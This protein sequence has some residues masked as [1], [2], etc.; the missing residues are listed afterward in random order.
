MAFFTV[1]RIFFYLSFSNPSDPVPSAL[2]AESFWIGFKFDLRLALIIN[3]PV[4][5]L[6]WI[7]PLNVFESGFGKRFWPSV[8]TGANV[9]LLIIYFIDFGHFAYLRG[10]INATAT[11]FFYNFS[12][13][14]GMIWETY[15]VVWAMLAVSIFGIGIKRIFDRAILGFSSRA[16]ESRLSAPRAAVLS[17]AVIAVSASGIYGKF[18]Y[19]PLRWS[20]AFFST[21]EFSSSLSLNPVLFFFDTF[22]KRQDAYDPEKVK[23]S[24]PLM[25]RYLGID[26]PDPSNPSY[27]RKSGTTGRSG[28]RPNVVIV[29]L[30][31][32]CYYKTGLSGNPLDPTPRF[33]EIARSGALF[34][35]YYAPSAG[36][37][38][39]IFALMTGIPDV[40]SIRTSSRNPLIVSQH[41]IAN[42]FEGYEK[43]YFLGGSLNWANIR[44]LLRHNISDLRIYEEGSYT[45]PRVDVWGISDLSLFEEANRVLRG[46]K[47]PFFAVIQTSGNHR[48]YTVPDDSRGFILKKQSEDEIKKHGFISTEEYNSFRFMDHSIGFFIDTAKKEDY[49]KNTIFVFLGDHG[50]PGSADHMPRS[51]EQ[52]LLTS[53]HVPFLIYA[54]GL[55]I[56]SHVYE[57][58]ASEV[59]V[60]PTLARLAGRP[61]VN[62]TFG[63]DLFDGSFSESRFAFT[64][65]DQSSVPEIGLVG[66]DYYFL[67]HADGS[68]RRL[69]A[70]AAADPRE[71]LTASLP[72]VASGME[73]VTRSIYETARYLPYI[74]SPSKLALR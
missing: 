45:S 70:L 31:S 5:I 56:K 6:S 63:R 37:A 17:F 38:R 12:T 65:R 4:F 2:L 67:M 41:T 33:D 73:T 19:Y 54:P 24:Y 52:L 27:V 48:P 8:L 21:N 23:E 36:T 14:M 40:E 35:R 26:H 60:L 44:G 46:Q 62:S 11:Q 39:S 71:N 69:H 53:N 16:V 59:D 58:V 51:E 10:R 42:D 18:S 9:L 20:D 74:N 25:I 29:I 68:N 3:L 64:V 55:N 28:S 1:M 61:Y 57:T 13:S 7:R 49:F 22:R 50:L 34:T 43:F 47:D 32:F 66:K 72:Y 30:E 15:P